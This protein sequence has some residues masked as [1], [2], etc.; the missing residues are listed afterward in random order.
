MV[1]IINKKDI[2]IFETFVEKEFITKASQT[3]ITAERKVLKPATAKTAID[4]LLNLTP[5]KIPF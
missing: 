1:F 5:P 3:L 2:K 4:D